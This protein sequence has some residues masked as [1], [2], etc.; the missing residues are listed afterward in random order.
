MWTMKR[1]KADGG[2]FAPPRPRRVIIRAR[3]TRTALGALAAVI[4]AVVVV[5]VVHR[6]SGPAL[7][8][9]SAPPLQIINDHGECVGSTDGSFSFDPGR[10]Q[11]D[12]GIAQAERD[13]AAQNAKVVRKG[14]YVTVALLTPLTWSPASAVTLTRIQDELDGAYAAQ[15]DAN[16]NQAVSPQI[17]LVLANE[18]SLEQAWSP[19]VSQLKQM[20]AAPNRLVAVIGMGVSVTATVDGAKALSKAGIPMVG[21][22]IT[23]DAL[24]WQHIPGLASVAPSNSQEVAALV[25]YLRANG[26]LSHAF[27]VSDSEASDLYTASLRQDFA[28]A[29]GARVLGDEPYGP[30]PQIGNQFNL[31]ADNICGIP[32]PPPLVIYAGREVVLGRFIHQL[33]G[34]PDCDSKKITVMTGSDASAIS[35]GLTA[36]QPGQAQQPG[37][38]QVSV[39]YAALINSGDVTPSF[40]R[41]FTGMF[42]SDGLHDSWMLETY[43][44]LAATARAVGLATGSSPGYPEPGVIMNAIRNLNL[45]HQ[46]QGATG[47]FSIG[48]NGDQ[49]SPRVPINQ[50]ADGSQ[51]TLSP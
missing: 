28:T 27:L 35:P 41:L 42:G 18:G 12:R 50:L 23:G 19:V 22:V 26:G 17:R 14:H 9:P 32:G 5:V 29:F 37:P 16:V 46:V 10:T 33:Q 20:T 39:R 31:I 4:A 24:N 6:P 36:A 48:L 25:S 51:S 11:A 7:C 2:I 40:Q 15:Y 45:E 1:N 3:L 49:I 44:A 38:A 34:S 43:D 47:P 8:V 30:G 13:I 21:S